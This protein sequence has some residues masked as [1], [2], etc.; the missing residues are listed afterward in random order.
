MPI[1]VCVG[2]VPEVNDLQ[3]EKKLNFF[4]NHRELQKNN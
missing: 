1:N 3:I 2:R 4:G